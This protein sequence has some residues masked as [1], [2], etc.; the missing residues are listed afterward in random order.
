MI[1]SSNPKNIR[2]VREMLKRFAGGALA[3]VYVTGCAH[4]SLPETEK[5]PMVDYYHGVEVRDDYRWL[6]DWSQSRVRAWS[7]RQNTYARAFLDALPGVGRLRKR[8]TDLLHQQTSNYFSLSR[9]EGMLFA[10]KITPPLNQPILVVMSSIDRSNDEK[11]V[12]DPNK[13]DAAGSMSMD[14]YVPSPDGALVAVSLSREGSESGDVYVFDTQS[15]GLVEPPVLGVNKGT[16]GGDLAWLPDGS[17]FYYTRYPRRGERADEDLD[18]F[19]Q[20]WFHKLKTPGAED[21]YEIGKDFPRIA[22]IR[23]RI[24][25]DTGRV[26]A[27]VQYGDS[28]RFMLM[29]RDRRASWRKI[30]G[31]DDGIVQAV[32]GSND[33]L[34]LISRKDAPRG[35]ILNMDFDRIDLDGADCVIPQSEHSIMSNFWGPDTLIVTKSRLVVVY[36]VG[37]PVVLKAFD[38]QGRPV[39]APATPPICNV[40]QVMTLDG[41]D[42]L[43][44]SETYIDPAAWYRYTAE[45]GSTE[46]TAL[47]SED[48]IDFHDL[49]VV[50]DVGLSRDGT[51]VP[52]SVIRPKNIHLDGSHP[53][54]LYGYG[55]YQISVR[56]RYDPLIRLWLDHGVLVAYAN[57]R[58]GGEY[59][60][61]WHQE[62][63]LTRKQNVFDDFYAVMR[64]LV[65]NGT[66]RTE[67]IAIRGGSNGGLL[68]GAMI[69]QHPQAFRA[70]VSH[71]GIYDMLR[72]E[73]SANGRFNIPE[74]G[75]VNNPEHF[76]A[77]Y[78]YS[79]YHRVEDSTAYPAVLLMTGAND[80]RV[81]PMHSRKMTA[82]L[83]QASVS[84]RPILL[85]T[86]SHTGHGLGTPL[87]ELISQ[88]V[89]EMAFVL[90]HLGVSVKTE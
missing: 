14:W 81:D 56:P 27:I 82:R 77:L 78:A 70:A 36:Q 41:D 87:D 38:F 53:V 10:Q 59:G 13:L 85:R 35:K 30:A 66:T 6:E 79:P 76:K 73:L 69:T 67:K 34:W 44:K 28:G 68:M 50:R 46:K 51:K 2:E 89:D 1:G 22:E 33:D 52:F 60:Q 43:F 64:R 42:I 4:L 80:P 48:R 74:Y 55:G 8:I 58:G 57:I 3:W 20:V 12:L 83:Q 19:Q 9:R 75:T 16:A 17:G 24:Q 15:C 71:V 26:L 31:F 62:G 29:L 21:R 86:N 84:G 63:R 39:E 18:F 11:V 49:E 54:I 65:E 45:G 23:L 5:F 25:A 90:E 72:S 40:D 88:K 47:A 37:G 32:F 61:T 7:D